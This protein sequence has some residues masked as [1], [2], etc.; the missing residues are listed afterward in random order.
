MIKV[1][2]FPLNAGEKKGQ[3]Q[4]VMCKGWHVAM[5]SEERRIDRK[6]MAAI[7]EDN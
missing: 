2:K 4:K 5:W 6:L 7:P 1:I 3:V